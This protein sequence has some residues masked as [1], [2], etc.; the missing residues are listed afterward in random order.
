[1][2]RELVVY[3]VSQQIL[4]FG[5][6][7]RLEYFINYLD[8]KYFVKFLPEKKIVL[9]MLDLLSRKV[10]K[11]WCD[12]SRFKSPQILWQATLF[13]PWKCAFLTFDYKWGEHIKT[14]DVLGD[15][16]SMVPI[17]PR[18]VFLIRQTF[19]FILLQLE[20]WYVCVSLILLTYRDSSPAWKKPTHPK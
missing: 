15:L 5:T 17:L 2:S 9:Q 12:I 16:N 10:C 14:F 13:F 6:P 19:F 7:C 11:I 4:K 18:H 3:R 1:M 8:Q 20:W